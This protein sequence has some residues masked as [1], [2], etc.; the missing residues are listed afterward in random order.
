MLK[1]PYKIYRI[2]SENTDDLI[3]IFNNN[4]NLEFINKITHEK[5]LGYNIDDFKNPS[6]RLLITHKDD[7]KKTIKAFRN[8]FEKGSF[9]NQLRLKRRDGEY[10]WFETKGKVFRDKNGK[11][12]MIC[13]SRDITEKKKAEE[14]L[15][16]SEKK[17]R[18]IIESIQ[19]GYFEID[20]K[21]NFT[22]FNDYFC[23]Y[24]GYSKEELLGKNYSEILKKE[25]LNEVFNTFNR[26]FKRD[27]PKAI[28]ETKIIR[29]DGEKCDIDGSF[30][31]KHDSN[32]EK[33]GFYGFTRDIT[34]RKLTEQKLKES[35]EKFR[36]L[37][38]NSPNAILLMNMNGEI[39]DCNSNTEKLSGFKKSDLIGKKFMD[40]HYIPQEYLP[41]ALEG[42]K[43]LLK[44]EIPEPQEIQLYNKEGIS[45]WVYY[46]GSLINLGNENLI[47][48]IIQDIGKIKRAEQKIK[49][50]EE[51]YRLIMDNLN[52]LIAVI[53]EKYEFEYVNEN[54]LTRIMGY[55]KED[56]IG[57]NVLNLLHPEDLKKAIKTFRNGFD[58]GEAELE[59]RTKR[60]DGTYKWLHIFGKTFID[61]NNQKKGLLIS[62]DIT[63]Q[64][65]A[66][67]ELKESAEIFKRF[68]EQSFVGIGIIQEDQVKYAN[69]AMA[70]ILEYSLEE[71]MTWSKTYHITNMI[72]P[73]D[74]KRLRKLRNARRAGDFN[75]KPYVSYRIT[76]KSDKI[77]WI[78]QYSK[79][80]LY[81]GREAELV[82]II[83]ITEK[84]EAERL[85]IE[86]NKKLLELN[87]MKND[88][89]IR[90]SHELKTPLSSIYG[91]SQFLLDAYKEKLDDDAL[92]FIKLIYKGSLRLKKL[93]ENLLD[94]SRLES[95]KMKLNLQKENL[96]KIMGDCI[97][98]GKYLANIRKIDVILI[99]I[100]K[101]LYL[102][103]DPIRI[104][105]VFTNIISNAIK[106]TP[107]PGKIFISMQENGN[108][109]EISVKDTGIGL[110]E[111]EKS[112]LF[113]K[114]GKIE[115]YGQ[116]LNL[117]IEGSGLG[118][119]ISNEIVQLHGGQ[120]LVSSKGRNKGSTFT[121]KLPKNHNLIKFS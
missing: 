112:T 79:I 82:I 19:D 17:Y 45:S 42:F 12:K 2:I 118:L 38:E 102:I 43:T 87:Q 36:S 92:D 65:L 49:E 89:V 96:V 28:F 3:S 10:L 113:K 20:L 64:K 44:G 41:I 9:I 52:E 74:L 94:A 117:D 57:M 37:F 21:G 70:D 81:H 18:N 4:F 59:L 22:F 67:Q 75:V 58:T 107:S 62:R 91:G 48:V 54:V 110:T 114:F 73:E 99:D 83:D 47:Q 34:E 11:K 24:L 85:I 16:E 14:I 66:E 61:R 93:V 119:F 63:A 30:Y 101:E 35:E 25:T 103:L 69:E 98:E 55:T 8:G 1:D 100:P 76:S 32:G 71:I 86:E 51:R 115:R 121:I 23:N 33:V 15:K 116:G 90:V 39:L 109:F 84:K 68:S 27:L 53:N 111:K 120:I 40:F 31:L 97:E 56:M 26:V 108:Y 7:V 104:G 46:Q 60:K 5:V 50:S 78:D 106:N 105:Q 77:I 13:I 29:N 95:G 80:I 6:F 72:H 88:F